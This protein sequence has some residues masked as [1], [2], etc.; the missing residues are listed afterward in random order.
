MHKTLIFS[1]HESLSFNMS[2]HSLKTHELRLSLQPRL[3]PKPLQSSTLVRRPRPGQH[4]IPCFRYTNSSI[5]I[6]KQQPALA[7]LPALLHERFAACSVL[8][9]QNALMQHPAQCA[10]RA[11]LSH[12][13]NFAIS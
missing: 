5:A 4:P 2:H 11:Q 3:C 8:T 6:S 13:T 7:W 9:M 12:E 1:Q 10:L